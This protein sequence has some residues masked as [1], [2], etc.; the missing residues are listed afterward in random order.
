MEQQRRTKELGGK[1][2]GELRQWLVL[3]FFSLTVCLRFV[4]CA[5]P[6]VFG[7]TALPSLENFVMKRKGEFK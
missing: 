1:T 6:A 5:A 4:F 7:S 2:F 3:S